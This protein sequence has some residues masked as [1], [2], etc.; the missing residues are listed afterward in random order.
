MCSRLLLQ[1][2]GLS[3]LV[4]CGLFSEHWLLLLAVVG[5]AALDHFG[6]LRNHI[7]FNREHLVVKEGLMVLLDGPLRIL[8]SSVGYGRRAKELAE[9]VAIEAANLKLA[10]LGE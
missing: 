7:V 5:V 6:G 3:L 10:D 2:Q 4:G 1:S 9:V 8:G